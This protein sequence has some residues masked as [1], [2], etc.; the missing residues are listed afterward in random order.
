MIASMENLEDIAKFA[1]EHDIIVIADEIYEK[2]I[3][4]KNKKHIS[5]ASLGKEIY[6]RTITI[7]GVSKSYAMTG[8]R[9]GYVAC[10]LNIAKCISTIQSHMSSN[11]NSMAQMAVLEALTGPQDSVE[12]MRL[13]FEKRRDY[14]LS[15]KRRYL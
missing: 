2:L 7:N 3:Y 9:I 11:P 15:V 1:V 5:I 4:N 6:D 12:S 8:W 13:Q 10:P 14:I